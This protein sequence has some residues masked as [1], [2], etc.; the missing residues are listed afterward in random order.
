MRTRASQTRLTETEKTSEQI[1]KEIDQSRRKQAVKDLNETFSSSSGLR[2]L[3]FLMELCGY[4]KPSVVADPQSGEIQ[5]NSTVYNEARR[6]IY[7]TLR[8]CL[9]QD[10]LIPVEN[11]GLSNDD[12]ETLFT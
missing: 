9:K 10:I 7:L 12:P 6:N 11:H 3:R 8:K 2:T 4:Q 5:I 1:Q